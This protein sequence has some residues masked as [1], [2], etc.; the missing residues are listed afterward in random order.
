MLSFHCICFAR[1]WW[2]GVLYWLN[3]DFVTDALEIPT[4]NIIR[5]LITKYSHTININT[6]AELL[7]RGVYSN[8]VLKVKVLPIHLSLPWSAFPSR[9]NHQL[10]NSPLTFKRPPSFLLQTQLWNVSS[11][12]AQHPKNLSIYVCC[13]P[14][15]EASETPRENDNSANTLW[16]ISADL[17]AKWQWLENLKFWAR[18]APPT[19]C[20]SS[21]FRDSPL[22]RMNPNC[23]I[24]A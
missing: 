16:I 15:T 2:R 18:I 14:E 23:N 1:R 10:Y 12:C 5:W 4:P 13:H 22:H 3:V 7:W 8:V 6:L 11:S 20:H 19:K 17:C 9:P 24:Y 21:Y